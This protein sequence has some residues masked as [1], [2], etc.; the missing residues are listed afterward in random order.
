MNNEIVGKQ[1]LNFALDK[2][3]LGRQ[4]YYTDLMQ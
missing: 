4:K 2:L 1:Y 3:F